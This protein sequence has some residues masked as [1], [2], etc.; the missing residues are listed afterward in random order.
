MNTTAKNCETYQAVAVTRIANS[1]FEHIVDVINSLH[2][3]KNANTDVH[4]ADYRNL[5]GLTVKRNGTLAKEI[6][7]RLDGKYLLDNDTKEL[8]F[9]FDL[10][11]VAQILRNNGL[12]VE[13]KTYNFL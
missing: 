12:E 6:V 11:P 8:V 3:E 9:N 4:S 2:A 1:L 13:V 7:H 5:S 10:E